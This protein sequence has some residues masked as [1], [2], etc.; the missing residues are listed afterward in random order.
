[1]STPRGLFLPVCAMAAQLAFTQPA[2]DD[3]CGAVAI[4]ID[5]PCIGVDGSLVDASGTAGIGTP[6]CGNYLG[7]D[8]WFSFTAPTGL[9]EIAMANASF[10]DGALALYTAD[11]CDG[12]FLLIACD[13]DAGPGQLPLISRDD[14]QPGRT[15]WIRAFGYGGLTGTFSLCVTGPASFPE[16]D[17]VYRL[18]L[19]DSNGDG[20]QAGT[21]GVSING[22]A[23]TILTC[24]TAD[25]LLLVGLSVGDVLALSYSG[26]SDANENRYLLRYGTNGPAVF[27][28]GYQPVEGVAFTLENTC[29]PVYAPPVDCAYRLPLCADT[30]FPGGNGSTGVEVDL[31]PANQGFVFFNNLPNVSAERPQPK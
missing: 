17:C 9:A 26:G 18:E 3:P 13:D 4:S 5:V 24:A 29:L 27:D 8:V 20:W 31:T 19:F 30:L 1:M 21:L 14:L 6:P 10:V 2:N 16:G 7:G 12:A 11:S 15:Y 23:P 22:N 28:S 25:T